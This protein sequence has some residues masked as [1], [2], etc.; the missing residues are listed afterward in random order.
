MVDMEQQRLLPSPP[1][2]ATTPQASATGFADDAY[3]AL[4]AAQHGA[5]RKHSS[6]SSTSWCTYASLAVSTLALGF[7]CGALLFRGPQQ[8]QLQAQK[9]LVSAS[10]PSSCA[11]SSPPPIRREW[12]SLSLAERDAYIDAV[13]C[14]KTRP[15]RL[16]L[17]HSLYDDFPYIHNLFDRD[18]HFAASFLPWHRYF[19]HTYHSALATECAYAAELPYWDWTLDWTALFSSPV[20]DPRHGFSGN[21][22]LS[23]SLSSSSSSSSSSSPDAQHACISSGRFA[24][25]SVQYRGAA[26]SPHCLAR[27]FGTGESVDELV[28]HLRPSAIESLIH[29]PRGPR[30]GTADDD[31]YDFLVK[32]EAGPHLAIPK[33]VMGD[34]ALFTSP[35]DPVFFLHHSNLDRLWWRWEQHNLTQR[36]NAYGGDFVAKGKRRASVEDLVSLG[37]LAPDV[38][39]GDLL[40]L[41][42]GGVVCYSY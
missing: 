25:F 15:S 41:R 35:N 20:W 13:L 18:I 16:G 38:R 34:F 30:G 12:R 9:A 32:L 29:G 42:E 26:R 1:P 6:S 27:A 8:Q 33:A 10:S 11:S 4:E 5:D 37:G 39:V 17:A 31:Y 2:G 3:H 21:G 14:L 22:S 23:S 19:I 28:Q 24:H 36:R 7:A 40:D